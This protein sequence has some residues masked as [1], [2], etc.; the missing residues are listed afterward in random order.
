MKNPHGRL[1]P[2]AIASE[3]AIRTREIR[4]GTGLVLAAFLL[5]HFCNHALGLIS[6]EAM[7]AGR[8]WFN[9]LWRNP[10]GT[11]L[12]YGS[13]LL[14]FLLALQA[15]YRRRTLRMPAREAAQLL[16]GLSLPFLLIGHVTGT[17]VEW[18]LTGHDSG[19]PEVVRSLWLLS[20][21]IGMR[22]A[23]T[24]VIAWLHGC[25][26]VYFWL[27]PKPWFPGWALL[28]YTGAISFPSWL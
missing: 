10:V 27:R 13:V 19:Y 1:A 15:L 3:V 16:L 17:R 6:M 20:P 8:A 12:L 9:R 25:L 7:E 11:A 26:G 21:E 5:T 14:H 23:I 22:Q 24:L 4:L 28:L 2:E 18:A